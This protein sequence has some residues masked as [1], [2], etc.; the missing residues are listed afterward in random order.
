LFWRCDR[1]F[2]EFYRGAEIF[3]KLIHFMSDQNFSN[4]QFALWRKWFWIGIVAALSSMIVGL[5]YG[6]ALAMEKER[7]KEGVIIAV[8]AVVWFIMTIVLV[9]PWLVKTGVLPHYELFNVK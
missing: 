8:F 7:R 4:S 2:F 9:G 5:V 3:E 1:D 6:I